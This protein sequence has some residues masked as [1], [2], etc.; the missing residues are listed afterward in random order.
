MSIEDRNYYN[1]SRVR[2]AMTR[3]PYEVLEANER[4]AKICLDEV[5]LEQLV[6]D[7]VLEENHDG[8]LTGNTKF[9]VCDCCQGSG[10][11]VNPSIDCNGL[12]R[13]DFADDPDFE[14]DYFSGVYDITCTQCRGEK[15]I[16][17]VIFDEK[18]DKA[19]EEWQSNEA[20]YA[21]E[22]AA[23]MRMGY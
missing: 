9:E 12:S 22:R 4:Q 10:K 11:T 17:R 20:A 3:G 8:I 21:A 23:E 14:R 13:E 6:D 5:L 15:V 1:D 16:P 19:I 2:A 7:G 18:I